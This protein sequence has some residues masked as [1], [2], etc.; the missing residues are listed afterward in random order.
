M[1]PNANHNEQLSIAENVLNVDESTTI[2]A[3][4]REELSEMARN[5]VRLSELVMALDGW[6]KKGGFLPDAWRR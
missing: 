2:S 6:I 5:A 4:T 1:D 3:M